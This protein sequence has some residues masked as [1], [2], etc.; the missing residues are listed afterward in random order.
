MNEK[1]CGCPQILILE[2]E[3]EHGTDNGFWY[4][5]IGFASAF[6]ANLIYHNL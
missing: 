4:F 2:R 1:E 3:D 5:A 6:F